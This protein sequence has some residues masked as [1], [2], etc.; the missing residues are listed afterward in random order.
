MRTRIFIVVEMII[1]L[2]LASR[3]FVA[4]P[5]FIPAAI[6]AIVFTLLTNRANVQLQKQIFAFI[7]LIAWVSIIIMV[8]TTGYFWLALVW[9]IIWAILFYR[10]SASMGG[11]QNQAQ[12]PSGFGENFRNGFQNGY[13]RRRNAQ[14]LKG[15][16][17]ITADGTDTTV[18]ESTTTSDS[19]NEII[20]L[21][22]MVFK[23]EGNRLD[24]KKSSGNVKILVPSDVKINVTASSMDGLVRLMEQAPELD[25]VAAHF[26][27][28]NFEKS[29][30]RVTITVRVAQGNI[31]VVP[32]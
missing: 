29:E 6:I 26:E 7:A 5:A 22:D 24:I 27:S 3:L 13:N 28:P 21:F 14:N 17:D 31:E 2:L 18:S 20:D 11:G 15:P 12:R 4:R 9:P 16:R 23:P 1:L 25:A 32:S 10:P 30:K 19:G 8:I